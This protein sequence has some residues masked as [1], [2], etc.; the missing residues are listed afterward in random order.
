M[1]EIT[2]TTETAIDANTV[3][4]PDFFVCQ[5]CKHELP[6]AFCMRTEGYC[7]L[8]DPNIDVNELLNDEI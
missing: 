3:L 5:G 4:T 6:T 8:C 7:Y 2:H 1:E